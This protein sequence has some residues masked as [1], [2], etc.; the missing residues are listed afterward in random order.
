VKAFIAFLTEWITSR[1]VNLTSSRM[2]SSA[3]AI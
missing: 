3:G 2:P 1:E